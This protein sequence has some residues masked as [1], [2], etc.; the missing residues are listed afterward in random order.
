[1]FELEKILE[2]LKELKELIASNSYD[3]GDLALVVDEI[4][5][6]IIDLE[7]LLDEFQR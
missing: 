4:D 2:F 6:H 7:R 3:A 1:M 5:D